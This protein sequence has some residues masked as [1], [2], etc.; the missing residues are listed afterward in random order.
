MHTARVPKCSRFGNP[1]CPIRIS[2]VECFCHHPA[3][4]LQSTD[5]LRGVGCDRSRQ[6][7]IWTTSG[8]TRL[9]ADRDHSVRVLHPEFGQYG[10]VASRLAP[11]SLCLALFARTY[12]F[13]KKMVT[14]VTRYS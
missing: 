2:E 8:H 4:L 6:E 12:S 7:F 1:A 3:S 5:G 9:V 11:V 14:Y 10:A 13:N